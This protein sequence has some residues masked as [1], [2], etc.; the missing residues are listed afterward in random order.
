MADEIDLFNVINVRNLIK[1]LIEKNDKVNLDIY[2]SI[3]LALDYKTQKSIFN[4]TI[5]DLCIKSNI[6]IFT[7]VVKFC[8]RTKCWDPKKIFHTVARQGKLKHLKVF[9]IHTI[10]LDLNNSVLLLSLMTEYEKHFDK[11]II[12]LIYSY[13]DHNNDSCIINIID[14]CIKIYQEK[15]INNKEIL[16]RLIAKKLELDVA[17]FTERSKIV[18]NIRGQLKC[19]LIS[20]N[21]TFIFDLI[22]KLE[23]NIKKE[24]FSMNK[25]N[26]IFRPHT[27]KSLIEYC[28]ANGCWYPEG[29][30]KRYSCYGDIEHL[31]ILRD[32]GKITTDDEMNGANSTA[33]MS[34]ASLSYNTEI[35][36]FLLENYFYTPKHLDY[37]IHSAI[38]K[39]ANIII[40]YLNRIKAINPKSNN[41]EQ[42]KSSTISIVLHDDKTLITKGNDGKLAHWV[43][44]NP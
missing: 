6:E 42:Q 3:I 19:S 30:L 21:T 26:N 16:D 10:P 24:I 36:Q 9:H 28:I 14:K 20:G 12:F 18:E 11:I 41:S 7:L 43:K 4:E 34:A 44:Q 5:W 39:N 32:V 25:M 37:V 33:L 2:L 15:D 29:Y 23:N 27:L 38:K 31:K 35:L 40:E 22:S 17:K 8:Y 13:N 1:E